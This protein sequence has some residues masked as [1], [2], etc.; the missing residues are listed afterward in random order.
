MARKHII[1]SGTGRSGTTF[2]VQLY[3]ALG[4]DTGFSDVT[5]DV[6]RHCQAG[7]EWD[8]RRPDAP[9]IVKSPW[10]CS[11]L[12]EVLA[13]REIVIEHALVPVRDLYAAAESRRD[14]T[15]RAEAAGRPTVDVPGGLW[16]TDQPERQ[17]HMLTGQFY[18]LA[19]TLAQHDIPL[20]LLHF[21]RIVQDPEYLYRKL[22]FSLRRVSA[23]RFRAT[24]AAVAR[25]DLVHDFSAPA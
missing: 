10:L 21:P 23:R 12:G 14:V 16:H 19:Y 20:T 4:L 5:A 18:S 2:L 9:Y 25:P 11:Y 3:T 17:E 15:R 8:L 1:I 24:F 6:N 22:A 7:L 13:N